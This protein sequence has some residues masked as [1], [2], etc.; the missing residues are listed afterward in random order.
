MV[1]ALVVEAA[2]HDGTRG[3]PLSISARWP[4]R[5][6]SRTVEERLAAIALVPGFLHGRVGARSVADL[7]PPARARRRFYIAGPP[8]ASGHYQVID[9][10]LE[11]VA[12]YSG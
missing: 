2:A 9:V 7:R 12:R 10:L 1:Y 6:I 3:I 11:C 4:Q 5:L 8:V